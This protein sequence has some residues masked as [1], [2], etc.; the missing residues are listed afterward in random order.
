MRLA[1]LARVWLS[2]L[3]NFELAKNFDESFG[4]V[5]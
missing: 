5:L 4:N 3:I 2:T 1:T